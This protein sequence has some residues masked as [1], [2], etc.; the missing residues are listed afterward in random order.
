LHQP[1]SFYVRLIYSPYLILNEYT[2]SATL[3]NV[4]IRVVYCNFLAPLMPPK[5]T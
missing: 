4:D 3:A 1:L 5:P 2:L